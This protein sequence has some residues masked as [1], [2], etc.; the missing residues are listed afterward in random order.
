MVLKRQARIF[1]PRSAPGVGLPAGGRMLRTVLLVLV[2]AMAGCSASPQALGL[3]G[4]PQQP[5]PRTP[6]DNVIANPGTAPQGPF[7]P[8]IV[9]STGSGQYYGY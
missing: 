9:P 6:G 4:A 3:T 7:N 1:G 2:A 5:P 8:T